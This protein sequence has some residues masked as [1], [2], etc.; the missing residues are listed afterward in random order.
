M[1]KS[2]GNFTTIRGLLDSGV[3]PMTLRL[4]VLQ[5]HYRKPLDFTADAL[6]AAATGW[7][8]LAAALGL[9]VQLGWPATGEAE[10][11]DPDL[12][13]TRD[14]FIA[15]MDDDLNTAAA[16]AV[17]FDLARPLRSLARRLERGDTAAAAEGAPLQGRWRLLHELAGVLGLQHE[18]EA[19]ADADLDQALAARIEER[20]QAKAERRYADADRIRDEL[21][22]Q[23]IEL[24][25]RPGGVTDW[26][27]V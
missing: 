4:F 12:V 6:A 8:G 22:E 19:A 5:A 15:A 13:D 11:T 27:R 16:L 20:R 9:G 17:L 14:R 1:S 10:G 26:I 23:G 2:L 21:R 3:T 18:P 24:I 25:D 7:Q